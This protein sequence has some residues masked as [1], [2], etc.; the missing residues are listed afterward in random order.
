EQVVALAPLPSTD[1]TELFTRRAQAAK[2]GFAPSAADVEAITPLVKL[3]EGM[4]LAIELA[5][6]RVSVMPPR[7]LLARMTDRFTLLSSSGRR[8]DRQ[9]TLRGVFDWSWELLSLPEKATLAQLSVFEGGFTLEAVE[10][11]LDLSPFPDAPWPPDALQSLVHKSLVRQVT[12]V[13]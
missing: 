5:A 9:A 8:M 13:R 2:P 4:P 12:D 1:A 11:V 3:L 7:Q 10:A 6:A